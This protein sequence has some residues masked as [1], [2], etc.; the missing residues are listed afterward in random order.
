MKQ[1]DTGISRSTK[2]KERVLLFNFK[3]G[4]QLKAVQTAL[5]L[6]QMEG[7][8]VGKEEYM[9][10]M[11][12]L[13]D[14]KIVSAIPQGGPRQ[15]LAGQM[16]VFAGLAQE[17]LTGLLSLLRANPE[18]GVIPYKAILTDT[19]KEWNAYTLLE[20]LKKEHMAMHLQENK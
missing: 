17:R 12:L 15:E 19:N 2:T 16:M 9:L 5:F 11:K 4:P 10:P 14:E 7:R 8:C 6:M 3:E 1:P 13:L 20:E 18:C